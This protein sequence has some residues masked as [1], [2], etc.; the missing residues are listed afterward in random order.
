VTLGKVLGAT[1]RGAVAA[2]RARR[3]LRRTLI[4]HSTPQAI[5]VREYERNKDFE[6]EA[7]KLA[8]KG[9][10]VTSVVSKGQPSGLGRF[11][12]LGGIGAIAM[13]PGEHLVVTYTYQA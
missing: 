4:P 10:V 13:R 6:R 3:E 5:I 8:R 9:Y 2:E 11:I 7:R 12:A 1:W